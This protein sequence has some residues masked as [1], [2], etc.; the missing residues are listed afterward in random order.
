MLFDG[1]LWLIALT[2]SKALVGVYAVTAG[3]VG[4]LIRKLSG[5]ERVLVA[6]CGLAILCPLEVFAGSIWLNAA[7]LVFALSY[8][9]LGLRKSA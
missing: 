1:P 6:I 9:I 7:G 8:M 3:I 4:F 2:T 5:Y